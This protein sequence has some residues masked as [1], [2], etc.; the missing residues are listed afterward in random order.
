[1]DTYTKPSS[2]TIA[3][4]AQIFCDKMDEN[5]SYVLSCI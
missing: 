3:D 4:F 5:S 1:M 2:G